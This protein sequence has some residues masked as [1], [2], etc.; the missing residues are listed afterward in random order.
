VSGLGQR[1][2]A[3]ERLRGIHA[4][5]HNVSADPDKR[6]CPIRL[7]ALISL[8]FPSGTK[9]ECSGRITNWRSI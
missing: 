2:A 1:Q 6:A 8:A 7:K 9:R 4:G 3:A 5:E